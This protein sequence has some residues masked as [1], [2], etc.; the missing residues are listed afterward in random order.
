MFKFFDKKKL[1]KKYQ[2]ALADG[3]ITDQEFDE[4]KHYV[5][6]LGLKSD[7]L[8]NLQSKYFKKSS[9]PLIKSIINNRRYSPEDEKKL[10]EISKNHDISLSLTGDIGIM[11]KLWEIENTGEFTPDTIEPSGIRLQKNEVCFYETPAVWSQLKIV[12][13]HKGFIGS[14]IGFRVAKGVTLRVGRA[15]PVGNIS[16]ELVDICDGIFYVTNKKLQFIGSKR[17]TSITYKRLVNYNLFSD[18]IEFQKTTGK[19]DMFSFRSIDAEYI[20][21]IL[22]IMEP[23]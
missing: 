8:E 1:E 7:D 4:L 12:K 10:L 15:F 22:Q 14:S 9:D 11:R 23:A 13:E 6:E 20:D 19:N 16:E 18:A 21:A 3:I 17:S 5:K 2:E